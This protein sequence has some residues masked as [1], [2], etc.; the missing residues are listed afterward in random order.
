MRQ[1]QEAAEALYHG[2]GIGNR[3]MQCMFSTPN[4]KWLLDLNTTNQYSGHYATLQ[5]VT[6][7]PASQL[8]SLTLSGSFVFQDRKPYE[9]VWYTTVKVG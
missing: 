5:S 2:T 7:N 4:T 3:L 6:R 9:A 8:R 1:A